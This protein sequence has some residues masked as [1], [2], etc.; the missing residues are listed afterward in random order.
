MSDQIPKECAT[1]YK[2]NKWKN[3]RSWYSTYRIRRK[4][5]C[6]LCLS[7]PYQIYTTKV[8]FIA[9]KRMQDGVWFIGVCIAPDVSEKSKISNTEYLV[10]EN[11]EIPTYFQNQG[12]FTWRSESSGCRQECFRSRVKPRQYFSCLYFTWIFLSVVDQ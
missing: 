3:V 1:A 5:L 12:V 10:T 2:I 6:V 7:E 11:K 9:N 8:R 4:Y